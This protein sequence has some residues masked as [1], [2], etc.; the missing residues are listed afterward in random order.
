MQDDPENSYKRNRVKLQNSKLKTVRRLMWFLSHSPSNTLR[1]LAKKVLPLPVRT[2]ISQC[3]R[4]STTQ[5]TYWSSRN[6]PYVTPGARHLY[7]ISVQL[8]ILVRREL[9]WYTSTPLRQHTLC[10]ESWMLHSK[11]KKKATNKHTYERYS[12]KPH[13]SFLAGILSLLLTVASESLV[14]Y[15]LPYQTREFSILVGILSDGAR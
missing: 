1:H 10:A 6:L 15:L 3:G 4:R 11:D 13:H 5:N 7:S 14:H 9:V 2:E 8:L 12:S